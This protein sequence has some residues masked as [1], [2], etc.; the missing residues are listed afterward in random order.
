MQPRPSK[1]PV[2]WATKTMRVPR[3]Q[4]PAGLGFLLAFSTHIITPRWFFAPLVDPSSTCLGYEVWGVIKKNAA[5]PQALPLALRL[6]LFT[7]Y[8]LLGPVLHC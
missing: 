7:R 8:R 5:G 4:F 3:T 1:R 2:N 6:R